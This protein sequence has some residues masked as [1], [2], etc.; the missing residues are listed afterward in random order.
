ML[1]SPQSCFNDIRKLLDKTKKRVLKEIV[2]AMLHRD[3]LF[4]IHPDKEQMYQYIL[5]I[6]DTK[7]YN[8]KPK[9]VKVTPK[10]ICILKFPNKG[11]ELIRL[12]SIINDKHVL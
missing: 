10:N 5:D 12:P 7:L 1:L 3:S 9:K 11:I 2:I 4:L 6:I 8:C